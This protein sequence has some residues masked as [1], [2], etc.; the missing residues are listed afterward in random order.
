MK[1]NIL[2]TIGALATMLFTS[3]AVA[4]LGFSNV[5]SAQLEQIIEDLSANFAHTA[6]TGAN[7]QGSIFGFQIG[8]VGGVTQTPQLDTLVSQFD[9]SAD[10]AGLPHGGMVGI[11]SVPFGITLEAMIIPSMELSGSTFSNTGMALKWTISDSIPLPIDVALRAH[12]ATTD[13]SYSQLVSGVDTKVNFTDTITGFQVLAGLNLLMVRPYVGVG[14]ISGDGELEVSG[15]QTIFDT[16]FTA[17]TKASK[18]VNST[19][20]LVGAE[21]S[22]LLIKLGLEYSS[23]FDTDRYTAKIAVGF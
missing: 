2:I 21:V 16:S 18:K 12:Y 14:T 20:F 11:L 7:T 15:S 17:G 10:S 23:Q 5:T 22:L 6:V 9:S 3:P 13:L 1:K 8:V 19:Q 4:D